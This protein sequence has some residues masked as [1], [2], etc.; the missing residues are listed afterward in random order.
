MMIK[1]FCRLIL[2]II[3]FILSCIPLGIFLGIKSSI[4]PQGFWQQFA[5]YGLGIYLFGALQ[6][7]L[8]I[9]FCYVLYWL[10]SGIN[11]RKEG[12]NEL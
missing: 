4:S 3:L 11:F 5:I 10:M 7:I 1:L 2:S 9:L 6:I 8:W 12:Q